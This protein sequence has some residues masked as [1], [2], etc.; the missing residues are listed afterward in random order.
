MRDC[1]CNGRVERSVVIVVKELLNH[2]FWEARVPYC[3]VY[4]YIYKII[5]III[6]IMVGS[7]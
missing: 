4:I 7:G 1:E 2:G 3:S 5:I 6:I